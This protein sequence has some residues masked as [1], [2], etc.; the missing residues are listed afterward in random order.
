M[1]RQRHITQQ[2]IQTFD[3]QV[4]PIVKQMWSYTMLDLDLLSLRQ[5]EWR[6][7]RKRSRVE[8]VGEE[9]SL[10]NIDIEIKK[11]PQAY[12]STLRQK[13]QTSWESH[14]TVYG[15]W[16]QQWLPGE[17][18]TQWLLDSMSLEEKVAQLFIFWFDGTTLTEDEQIFLQVYQPGGVIVM[19]KNV[20]PTLSQ[21]IDEMQETQDKLPL[22]VSIDQE[23]WLVARIAEQLPSQPEIQLDEICDV[24]TTRSDALHQLGVNM[25]FGIVADVTDNPNSFIY[26]RVFWWDVL[27]KISEATRCT[28][29]TLS[30][31]KH[32]PWHGGTA[33][34]THIGSARLTNNKSSREQADLPPFVSGVSADAD[35]IM[36]WHLIADHIDPDRPA[37]LS[38]SHQQFLRSSEGLWFDGLTVTDDMLMISSDGDVTTQL[39]QALLAG[40]DLLLYVD[41]QDK[42]KLLTSAIDMIRN[43]LITET[44]LDTR[45]RRI[46]EKK[47]K[48]ISRDDVVPLELLAQ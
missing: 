38:R 35:L 7:Q 6:S 25:N 44:E 23:W 28:Q 43:G 31:L 36:M 12:I 42:Q 16:T 4:T 24:Y 1:V 15:Q 40:H 11:N 22:F 34:D 37:T 48:I 21:L 2:I 41:L 9:L 32:R 29:T 19:G 20:S 45:L 5:G 26:P 8:G 10:P 47:Q 18:D 27:A 14:N 46:I 3:A 33:L 30:T 17:L 13:F 39:Q